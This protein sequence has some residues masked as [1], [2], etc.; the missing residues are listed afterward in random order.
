MK[1]QKEDITMTY[2]DWTWYLLGILYGIGI[3]LIFKVTGV[4]K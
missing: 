3:F 4:I 2:R 1:T